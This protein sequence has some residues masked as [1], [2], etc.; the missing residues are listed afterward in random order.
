MYRVKN[1]VA[2]ELA[3]RQRMCLNKR[4]SRSCRWPERSRKSA[5]SRPCFRRREQC[6]RRR[7]PAYACGRPGRAAGCLGGGGIGHLSVKIVADDLHQQFADPQYRT[8]LPAATTISQ[9][10]VVLPVMVNAVIAQITL[11]DENRFGVDWSR[12]ANNA[13]MDPISTASMTD[14]VPNLGGLMFS[15]GS[16]IPLR[17]SRRPLRPLPSITMCV[18]WPGCR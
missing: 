15:K 14:F 1:L 10:D 16:S 4:M 2:Q 17:G 5:A 6:G 11:N 7:R 3:I 13:A 9:L 8:G 18:C 12:I